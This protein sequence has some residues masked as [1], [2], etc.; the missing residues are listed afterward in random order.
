MKSNNNKVASQFSTKLSNIMT[1]FKYKD[2][3]LEIIQ[4]FK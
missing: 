2:D 4:Q 1:K 3:K